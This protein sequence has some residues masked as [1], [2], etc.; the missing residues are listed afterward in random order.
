MPLRAGGETQARHASGAAAGLKALPWHDY[1][2]SSDEVYRPQQVANENITVWK[3]KLLT[4]GHAFTM[5]ALEKE[6]F[7]R[8]KKS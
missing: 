6:N 3:E 4:K 7:C 2:L 1:R 5:V 8:M